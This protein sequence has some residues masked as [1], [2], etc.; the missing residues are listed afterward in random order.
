MILEVGLLA[1]EAERGG[2]DGQGGHARTVP[3][4]CRKCKL[5]SLGFG[6]LGWG[7][8]GGFWGA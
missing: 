5:I 6:V 7:L 3:K 1:Q 2:E 8:R 4:I